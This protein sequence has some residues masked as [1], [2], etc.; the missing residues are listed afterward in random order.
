[1]NFN[2]LIPF[3]LALPLY[4]VGSV[5]FTDQSGVTQ[6]NRPFSIPREFKCGDVPNYPRPV[7]NGTPAATWQ[8]DI[9][10]RWSSPTVC[11]DGS[12]KQS[13]VSVLATVPAFG[14]I[15]I[16]FQNSST[17]C[18]SGNQAA[19]DAAALTIAQLQALSWNVQIE[20]VASS[21]TKT[22]NART[23]L[24][25]CGSIS[26][27]A[28]SLG[29]RYWLRGP[30]RSSLIL[31][32]RDTT[33]TW[34][35]GWT[36]TANCTAPYASA[37]WVSDTTNKS[38][39]PMFNIDFWAST[40][41]IQYRAVAVENMWTTHLQDQAY[42]VTIK[43]GAALA[44][45]AYSKP[46]FVHYQKNRW[47]QGG[48]PSSIT[49]A[50]ADGW[51]DSSAPGA[52]A[53]NLNFPYLISTGAVP[54]YDTSKS[55]S[56]SGDNSAFA[57]STGCG[58]N[59]HSL[60]DQQMGDTGGRPE[61]G[62][63]P[64]WYVRTL[65][66][67]DPVAL[68]TMELMSDC[69]GSV[70]V[71]VRE[72]GTGLF[73][74]S[75]HTVSAFGRT[76]SVDAHPTGFIGDVTFP[77][78]GPAFVNPTFTGFNLAH[79]PNF[80]YAPYLMSGDWY[81]YE[82]MLNQA[83]NDIQVTDPTTLAYGRNGAMGLIN[84]RA[85]QLRGQAWG[86]RDLIE[87]TAVALD[88]SPEAVYM[89]QKLA[90]NI[91]AWEGWYNIQNGIY[92][93][94]PAWLF[95]R[96]VEA[97]ADPNPL[98]FPQWPDCC[99]GSLG[100]L[101]S[102]V[103]QMES[104][105]E[106]HF[107]TVATGHMIDQGY[108]FQAVQR[109]YAAVPLNMALNPSYNPYL[110]GAYRVAEFFNSNPNH[111][112]TI[113]PQ[114]L[115]GYATSPTN[116]QTVTTWPVQD[117]TDCTAGFTHYSLA[118]ISFL[119]NLTLLP[120]DG[121][122]AGANAWAFVSNPAQGIIN[123][124]CLNANPMWA[125]LPRSSA[126]P[127][128]SIS[129]ALP[130]GTVGTSYG[131]HV[132]TANSCGIGTLTWSIV[133]G[134]LP[135]GLTGCSGTTGS[136]CTISGTPTSATGSP[137]TP[138]IRVTDGTGPNTAN[139]GYSIAISGASVAPTITS[140]NPLPPGTVGLAYSF[141]L[142]A[143][144]T[145]PISWTGT[146]LPAGL[147][148]S[149]SGILSG[150]PT[151]ATTYA[152][153][154]TATNSAGTTG[155]V[156]FSLVVSTSAIPP[157]I[158]STSPLPGGTVGVAYS[159]GFAASGSTPLSWTSTQPPSGLSLNPS[160]GIL[161]GTPT[162]TGPYAF[163]VTATNSAGS[164]GP[165]TFSLTV[166][167]V[168]PAI[169]SSSPLPTGIVGTGYSFQFLASGTGPWTWSA[170]GLPS[171]ASI[172]PSGV[173]SGVPSAVATTS[174]AVS[175]TNAAGS[176]GPVTFSLPVISRPDITSTSPITPGTVGVAYTFTFAAAGTTPITWSGT[177]LP[178]WATLHSATGVLDGTPN[179]AGTTI[180][181]ITA[182]NATGPTNPKNFTLVIAPQASGPTITSTSPM[183]T[184][185]VGTAYT[186]QFTGTNPPLSW[187][188]T[189]LPGW[190]SISASGLVIGT[191]T[192]AATTSIAVTV[193]NTAGSAGPTTFS[194]PVIIVPTITSTSPLP[195]GT[196]GVAY[197]FQFA[198]TGSTPITYGA[199]GLPGWA[200][201]SSGGLLTGTPNVN[202]TTTIAVTA[203]NAAGN[204]GPQN[205]S[206]TVNAAATAPTITSVSPIPQGILGVAY[207]FQFV[208]T[209][210]APVTWTATG[211]PGW[212]SLATNG[213]LTGTP[214][215]NVTTTFNVTA[216]NGTGA[217]GPSP[218]SIA[219]IQ[220]IPGNVTFTGPVTFS[221]G[222]VR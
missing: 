88:G 208:G 36:C 106:M 78:V 15:T 199:T 189:G 27:N 17:P 79:Q 96:N 209:G 8:S 49:V 128:C 46:Y 67:M 107:L 70:Q 34:D 35:Q 90:N 123:A 174:I 83:A 45:V 197:S 150:T 180:L 218:F 76:F 28:A 91:G 186:Y 87:T 104:P 125:F 160:T 11:A 113:W 71:N 32:D 205:F 25:A 202:T 219:V 156:T 103:Q 43:T 12:V 98:R 7:L 62:I 185:I 72:S 162:A 190:A 122:Y 206:L 68:R 10:T 132:L 74:D 81:T 92:N 84:G 187:S 37:T 64:G 80:S 151:T 94:S 177:N 166:S 93:G 116:Y 16:D 173:L 142:A 19:C 77:P 161:S 188:A 120:V 221:G 181:A 97:V 73:Y 201:L 40:S 55:P 9:Q 61:L 110:L 146:G 178:G 126:P 82:S 39:H 207:S 3:L 42:A 182:S 191:P 26:T 145:T 149:T 121:G 159:F 155:P 20:A 168:G 4:G 105:L 86:W 111:F 24:N 183:T 100:W 56:S 176:A 95:G 18:S 6:T 196:N 118:A 157:T 58:P 130:A 135:P 29:C 137:Y 44:H 143:T 131:S 66:T 203:T 211:L 89:G 115:A 33:R 63:I 144:G 171:W 23:I 147:T 59:G 51:W 22:F 85:Q 101:Q 136:I 41:Y 214:N 117:Q 200:S 133:S 5:T 69:Q 217:A 165:Q 114:V 75:A 141:Q 109:V 204:S 172:S 108:P 169:T 220:V 119:A 193:T 2:N 175:V 158:T 179:A 102:T 170:T 30:V 127:V 222:V 50:G 198:S 153:A 31:E 60:F 216:T 210:T 152:P 194:L 52:V 14:T 148:L 21:I 99:A 54:N 134:A 48:D 195:A 139:A 140:A 164:A 1:M 212:A 192:A 47:R 154:L 215:A 184:G 38:L 213:L 129:G 112:A 167:G 53:P 65:Y 138:T 163:D 13:V 57:S 124:G